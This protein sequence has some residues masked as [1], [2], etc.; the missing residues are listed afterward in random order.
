MKPRVGLEWHGQWQM[1]VRNRN[2]NCCITCLRKRVSS[3]AAITVDIAT[4][5]REHPHPEHPSMALPEHAKTAVAKGKTRKRAMSMASGMSKKPLQLSPRSKRRSLVCQ[6]SRDRL[7]PQSA[8]GPPKGILKSRINHLDDP[9]N[10]PSFSTDFTLH[11]IQ[12]FLV[13]T[14]TQ[15]GDSTR[16][17]L[18]SF[19]R[20]VSFAPTANVRYE[21][22][23]FPCII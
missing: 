20:R 3:R 14:Q 18:N 7:H 12:N 11:N 4:Q 13:E 6:L 2:R 10:A 8:Q 16:R 17:S 19:S 15:D 22:A 23:F 5:T 1:V 9:A 21:P